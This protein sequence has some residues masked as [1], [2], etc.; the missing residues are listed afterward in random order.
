VKFAVY[1]LLL[2]LPLFLDQELQYTDPQI[3]NMATSY[4]VGNLFG[5]LALGFISDF[6]YAKRSPV[7]FAAILVSFTICFVLTFSYKTLSP[8]MLGTLLFILGLLLGGMHH[9]L[10][11]TCAA[12]LGAHK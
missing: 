2:W 4:E 8:G 5:G 9:I 6:F 12:D 10:C 7:G 3:A 11:V 1:A